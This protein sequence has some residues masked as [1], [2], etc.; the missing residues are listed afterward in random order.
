M[1]SLHA[2]RT[3]KEEIETPGVASKEG[4]EPNAV[5]QEMSMEV[6]DDDENSEAN[7]ECQK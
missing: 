6:G 3:N 1:F 7:D 5:Q 2:K 4:G